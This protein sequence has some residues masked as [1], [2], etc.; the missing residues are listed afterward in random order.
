MAAPTFS[1]LPAVFL[2]MVVD[3]YPACRRGELA[4]VSKAFAAVFEARPADRPFRFGLV[5]TPEDLRWAVSAVDWGDRELASRFSA[6]LVGMRDPS[7]LAL[8]WRESGRR[9]DIDEACMRAAEIGDVPCLRWACGKLAWTV[10]P[11]GELLPG[12]HMGD[13]RR[14]WLCRLF[15]LSLELLDATEFVV[16]HFGVDWMTDARRRA[17]ERLMYLGSDEDDDGYDNDDMWMDLVLDWD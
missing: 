12:W 14:R 1:D 6:A 4:L 2:D 10:A 16:D 15:V 8:A 17:V 11:P 5:R 13:D 7:L 9:L 3:A